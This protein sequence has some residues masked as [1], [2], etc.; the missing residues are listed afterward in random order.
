MS[1]AELDE[2]LPEGVFHL[3]IADDDLATYRDLV[4]VCGEV[5]STSALPPS[6]Y[7]P[8]EDTTEDE[9]DRDPLYCPACVRLPA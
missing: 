4:A 9:R 7:P 6:C 1:A 3:L 2:P 5:V 8:P